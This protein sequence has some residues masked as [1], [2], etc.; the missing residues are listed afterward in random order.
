MKR[1]DILVSATELAA[2]L[3]DEQVLLA[4]C[5]FSLQDAEAG[6]RDYA[7]A[8]IPT[9]L[10][11]H[12][13]H[14]LSGPKQSSGGRHPLPDAHRFEVTMRDKGLN[15]NQWVVLYDDNRGLF[16]SRAWWMLHYFGHHKV[17]LL[18]GG[19]AG[20]CAA[21][22]DT[23]DDVSL[24]VGDGDFTARA[25]N[26][27]VAHFDEVHASLANGSLTLVDAREA[28]RFLGLEEPIDPIA[29]HIPG[30]FNLP[31]SET[32][33]AQGYWLSDDAQSARWVDVPV[34]K[35][36]VLYCGSGVTA[37]SNAVSRALAN[38]PDG[39]L[40]P[41]SWSDWCRQPNAPIAPG[42]QLK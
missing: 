19:L 9:A 7:A 21:G 13:N 35:P 10:Y 37:C 27:A 34:N 8:H 31:A 2:L 38:M 36:V 25:N 42:A 40:Y 32:T 22:F 41:G 1:S 24:P 16:A 28:P 5:R 3:T 30:A 29:G 4:D 26:T 6:E 15:S 20:W 39:K 14:D 33:D 11:W 18:D 23:S 17:L 12:L